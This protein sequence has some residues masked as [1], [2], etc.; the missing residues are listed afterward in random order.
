MTRDSSLR[1]P[2]PGD[3][4]YLARHGETEYNR[5][6][7][8][9]GR[10]DIPLNPTGRD[11]AHAL[12]DLLK[13]VPL[14]RAYVS[15]LDRA[16]VTA[17]IA[18]ED[19]EIPLT[20]EPR[21]I[22]IDFGLWDSTPEAEVKERWADDYLDYRTDMSRFHPAEGESARDAQARA[23]EWWDEVQRELGDGPEHMLVVAHQSINAVLACYVAE[24]G[25]E[26]A[27]EHFK[28]RPGEVIKIVPGPLPHISRLLPNIDSA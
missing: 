21:L 5:R 14:T 20:V 28:T 4:L 12:R 3:V 1:S 8:F 9:Q 19:H 7:I 27:W 16:R 17:A 2:S 26:A 15:P 22:E 6:K 11:Q 25:L 23:G 13:P 18:L 10:S 24:V